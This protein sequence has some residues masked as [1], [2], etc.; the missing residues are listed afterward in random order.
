MNVEDI[1]YMDICRMLKRYSFEEKMRIC[2]KYSRDL[3]DVNGDID[4]ISLHEKIYPWELETFLL[5][6]IK[7]TPE[8]QFGD[9]NGK[10]INK[11]IRMINGIRNYEHPSLVDRHGD[12]SFAD[13]FIVAAGL[14]QFDIQ[15]SKRYKMYR[16]NYIFNFINEKIDMKREF[17]N[18][19]GTSYKDF[20]DF[21]SYLTLLYG[22]QLQI[23][24]K[25][26]EYLAYEKYPKVFEQL[27]ISLEDYKDELDRITLKIED[28]ITCLRPSYKYPFIKKEES[29][30]FPLPHLLGRAI[31][32]SLLYRITEGNAELRD[33]IGKE[34][35]ENYLI[36]ILEEAEVYDEIYGE[37][38]FE[39]EHH[40]RAR[41]LDAMVREKDDYLL[42]DCKAAVPLIG[43]R[44]FEK[45]SH[46]QEIK[47]LTEKVE[48]VYKH[49]RIFLPKYKQYNPYVGTPE[50]DKE[51]LWGV[52]VVLEDSYIRRSLIY[53]N[54]ARKLNVEMDSAE[55]EWFTTHIK[56]AS[57]YDIERFCFVG[58]SL[59]EGLKDQIEKGNVG[60]YAFSNYNLETYKISN[61]NYKKFIKEQKNEYLKITKQLQDNGLFSK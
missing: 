49:L 41:T 40:N 39:M 51:H 32:S 2:H 20:L 8:Y 31:T 23:S 27:S 6:S 19:Y 25:V 10:N 12:I 3:I 44:L 56:I 58:R 45:K 33:K 1:D 52:T 18:F 14:I 53:E 60:D 37:K 30:Y 59:V 21:G 13:F 28:Y 35:L 26:V 9:F 11:F 36:K 24:N 5:L 46:E 38:E 7:A 61:E 43:L 50:I 17:L 15:E 57:M 48:Q 22:S 47:R 4:V 34:V 29:I 42:L 55:Y 16:Y 54:A